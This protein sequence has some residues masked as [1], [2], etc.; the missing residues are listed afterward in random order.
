MKLSLRARITVMF[1]ATTLG[2]GLALIGLVYAYLKLTPVPFLAQIPTPDDGLVIDGAVPITDE[3]LRRVLLASAAAL[4]LLT[5]V[6]GLIGWFVAGLVIKPLREIAHDAATV[7]RGDLSARIS[8]EGPADEVG[9]LAAALNAMLDELADALERQRRFASNASHEL[10]TPIAT[11]QTMADVALAGGDDVPLRETL[12]RIRE[13]NARAAETITALLQ[14]ANVDVRD[15]QEMNLAALCRDITRGQGVPVAAE[16]VTVT[17]SPALVRQAVENLVRNGITHGEDA[18]LTLTKVG[19]HAEIVV[20][21]G[22]P[23][24]DT[25]EI[26]TWVEPFARSQRT[27]GAGHGLGLALVD[28]I[29]KAHGGS[30]ELTP[31]DGGGLAATLR[32]PAWTSCDAA[33]F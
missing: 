22:G 19:Q 24:L 30:L 17:A 2:V 1:V 6:A 33:H 28:A 8:H 25:A 21:S 4:A 11:I 5:A 15:R 20:E 12:G 18:S 23:A 27:A 31:R 3:I 29:A 9:E 32:L 26:R 10:K 13:V 7:T 16:P 14:L